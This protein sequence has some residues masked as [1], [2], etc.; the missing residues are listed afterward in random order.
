MNCIGSRIDSR[1]DSCTYQAGCAGFQAMTEAQKLRQMLT[2]AFQQIPTEDR[3]IRIV[4][5][6]ER[7]FHQ[8]A[9]AHLGIYSITWD[10][11]GYTQ[12]TIPMMALTEASYRTIAEL[13]DN[14]FAHS[15]VHAFQKFTGVPEFIIRS[16]YGCYTGYCNLLGAVSLVGPSPAINDTLPLEPERA[17]AMKTAESKTAES[18][19]AESKTAESKT[20]RKNK[21]EQGS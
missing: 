14:R 15:A 20:E 2:A 10:V 16:Q 8:L 19:T 17:L 12:P 18:K 9:G 5:L 1:I 3:P 13:W 21:Q 7:W 4:Y 11:P 6:A